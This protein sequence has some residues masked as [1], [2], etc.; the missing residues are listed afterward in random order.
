MHSLKSFFAFQLSVPKSI[1][2]LETVVAMYPLGVST[3]EGIISTTNTC[4]KFYKE[5]RRVS[6]KYRAAK[7]LSQSLSLALGTLEEAAAPDSDLAVQAEVARES[8]RQLEQHLS[9]FEPDAQQQG[10]TFRLR[11]RRM[12]LAWAFDELDGKVAKLHDEAVRA[13]QPTTP[14]LLVDVL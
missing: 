2:R 4:V 7:Y 8:H 3:A 12:A 1:S 11:K 14:V 6:G 13:L 5:A 10:Q 9:R